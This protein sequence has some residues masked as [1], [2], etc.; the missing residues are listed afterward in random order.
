M[1]YTTIAS[2]M[3]QSEEKFWERNAGG[4]LLIYIPKEKQKI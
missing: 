3:E 2:Q 4:F 1:I